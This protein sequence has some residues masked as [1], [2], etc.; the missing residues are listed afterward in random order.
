MTY[1][2]MKTITNSVMVTKT[3]TC[4]FCGKVTPITATVEQWE[5]Y[6]LTD[7]PVQHIFPDM[8]A[9]ERELLITQMCADCQLETF[10]Y[11]NGVY[12]HFFCKKVPPF[13]LGGASSIERAPFWELSTCGQLFPQTFPHVD[14][15][16]YAQKNN[17]NA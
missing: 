10:G 17:L 11:Q 9:T 7:E 3:V 16:L 14:N 1:A 15:F 8:S 5:R 2:T 6:M 13:F 4:P 12:P